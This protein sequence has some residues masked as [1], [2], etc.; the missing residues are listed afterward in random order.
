[1]EGDIADVVLRL[2]AAALVGMLMGLER[3]LMK[4]PLGMRTLGLVSFVAALA[5]LSLT[6]AAP[7]AGDV[8]ATARVLQ[9][10]VQG[11]L[12]GIGFLGGGV[13]LRD[14]GGVHNLTTAAEVWA[15][16][17]FGIAAAVA[18][19]A[20]VGAAMALCAVLIVVFRLL[21]QRFGLRDDRR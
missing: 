3:L 4:K 10:V 8:Q 19:W 21:E 14:A 13:I 18:P 9:G 17:A 11:V 20:I 2:A 12:I 6:H 1:M 7:I 15:A 5:A 16:A